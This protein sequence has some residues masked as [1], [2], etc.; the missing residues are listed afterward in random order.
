[1]YKTCDSINT[2]AE[3][4]VVLFTKKGYQISE[5]KTCGHRFTLLKDTENHLEKV[6]ADE[7]FFEGKSGY[8]NYL[9]EKEILIKAGK[10]Y[11][12]IIGKFM[13]P[14]KILDIGC[15]AGFILKGFEQAGWKCYGVEPNETMASYGREQFN[16]DIRTGGIESFDTGEKFDLITMIEVIG[17]LSDLDK[18]M[19]SISDMLNSGGLAL[20][21]SMDMKSITARILGK[22]WHEYCPPSVLHW[23][24]DK[25]L[26]QLFNYYGFELIDKGHPVKRIS[27]KHAVA[28]L[29][30]NSPNIFFKKEI[31]GFIS[32][33]FWKYTVLYPPLD[34]KWYLFRKL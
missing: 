14:G 24:S 6:Y 18:S 11:A 26:T 21:E 17:V 34:M 10:R 32:R 5:C 28:V 31:F 3:E 20:I 9:E 15:A 8:P 4:K 30:E 13:Q 1:M 29:E 33:N 7:Y 27:I 23:F 12:S 2:C 16:L 19:K 25:T 22:G